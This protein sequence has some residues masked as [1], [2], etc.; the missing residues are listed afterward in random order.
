MS[1]KM[2]REASAI[3]GIGGR[4][5]ISTLMSSSGTSAPLL[6]DRELARFL[7]KIAPPNADGCRL[8][9][10]AQNSKGYG[11]LG[12]RKKGWLAHRLAHVLWIGPI[13]EDHQVDH[14]CGALRVPGHGPEPLGPPGDDATYRV[15]P[16][17]P[18]RHVD[19]GS[20]S[21]LGWGG[22]LMA[23]MT[24]SELK[25]E[26]EHVGI[27]MNDVSICPAPRLDFDSGERLVLVVTTFARNEH[28]NLYRDMET[29]E[30]ATEVR[31]FPVR[32]TFKVAS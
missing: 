24:F 10:G 6:T 13:P 27:A 14:L 26:F 11:C 18:Q 22:L 9:T 28:G 32:L 1:A 25:S 21:R 2:S 31:R 12:V 7:A 17:L 29:Q 20:T 19:S 8:W 23:G 4:T 3:A 16:H 5:P 30:V 15:D